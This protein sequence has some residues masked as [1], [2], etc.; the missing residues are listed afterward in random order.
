[1]TAVSVL[2]MLGLIADKLINV[3][4]ERLLASSEFNNEISSDSEDEDQEAAVD[5]EEEDFAVQVKGG[6]IQKMKFENM[7]QVFWL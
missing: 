6:E 7:Q 3:I 5:V 1:M 2:L 4:N